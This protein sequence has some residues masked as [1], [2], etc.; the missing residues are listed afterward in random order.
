MSAPKSQRLLPDNTS[1]HLT[2][3]QEAR[4][5]DPLWFLARQWQTGEFE[6]E[7]GGR[8]A[9]VEIT[10]QTH[11][12]EAIWRAEAREGLAPTDPLEWAVEREDEEGGSPAW[13]SA[14]LE[15]RF[16]VEA[17]DHM[18][19]AEEYEGW[20][21]DWYHFDLAGERGALS[22]PETSA[23]RRIVP[24]AL[25][26][27]GMP[28]SRWWRM[29]DR[30]VFLDSSDDPEPNALS[31]LVP[32]FLYVDSNNWYVVPLEERVGA[33]RRITRLEAVD[34]FGVSTELSPAPATSGA[35]AT[36]LFTL[37]G[38]SEAADGSFLFLP[39]VGLE[40]LQGEVVEEV[41]FA[42]D[43]DANVVWAMER[44]Y[45]DRSTGQRVNR[46]E[47]APP[48]DGPPADRAPGL[49][50]A[51]AYRLK[52]E[53]APHW[54]PYVPRRVEGEKGDG[55]VYLRR[56]RSLETANRENPQYRTRV[57]T[58]AWRLHEEEIPRVGLRVRRLWRFARTGQGEPRFWIGR[59]KDVGPRE[60]QVGMEYDYLAPGS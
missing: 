6:A 54:I 51:P 30:N 53:I 32:E 20:G 37:A 36:H 13:T 24:T 31:T 47:E 46:G 28:H 40:T 43:E 55:Q 7:N 49:E 50:G 2:E 3:A 12:V 10:S 42:R 21:L 39:N 19:Q 14:A 16:A 29:E 23:P 59:R 11:P 5:K 18:L 15:Y 8:L 25:Q 22:Q 38:E 60:H 56:A 44:W 33:L 1:P 35:A 9:F 34:A 27:R 58:E 41:E 26:F 4:V 57:V 48:P 45:F 17:G 52:S